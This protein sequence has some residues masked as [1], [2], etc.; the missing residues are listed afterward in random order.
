MYIIACP[1]NMKS[2]QQNYNQRAVFLKRVAKTAGTLTV[3]S[4]M[5]M[6]V[7]LGIK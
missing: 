3:W 2:Q 5:F 1:L 7:A 4:A 6:F